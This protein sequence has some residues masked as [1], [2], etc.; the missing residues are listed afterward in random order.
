MSMDYCCYDSLNR[1]AVA[2]EETYTSGGGYTA[3]V[4]RRRFSFDFSMM[5]GQKTGAFSASPLSRTGPAARG[6]G[7]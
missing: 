7:V 3:V 5:T 4:F 6:D 2:A 1:L